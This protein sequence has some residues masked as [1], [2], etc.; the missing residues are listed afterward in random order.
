M[1][2][3]HVYYVVLS[4]YIYLGGETTVT[5]NGT[6]KG[7]RNQEMALSALGCMEDLND[8]TILCAGTDGGDG[9]TDAAGAVVDSELLK[10]SK[11]MGLNI[12]DYLRNNDSY[13]FF[14][15]FG[16]NHLKPGQ[17]GTNV[18]DID[19]ILIN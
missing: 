11:Q 17:T 16:D 18:M 2:H 19:I 15:N 1:Q 14:N 6:G 3:Q 5:I 4:I 8:V 12:Q 10:E 7:G 13:H 9:P